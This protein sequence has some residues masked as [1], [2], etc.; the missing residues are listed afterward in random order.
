MTQRTIIRMAGLAL[1][2]LIAGGCA[3]PRYPTDA[4][5]GDAV[6]TAQAQ[7]TVNP[8]ASRNPAG[9]KGIDGAAAKATV[10]RY[11]KTYETPPA[12][13][14]VFAIGVGADTTSGGAQ[15]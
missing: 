10:D 3:H 7:Q 4:A 2:A 13:V 8:D 1:A 14:N 9:P 5:F 12:P 11:Q 6:R 15:R